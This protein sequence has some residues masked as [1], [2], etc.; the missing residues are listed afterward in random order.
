MAR[1]AH[2]LGASRLVDRVEHLERALRQHRVH[3]AHVADLAE[4]S[5]ELVLI[6][7]CA[8]L[9]HASSMRHPVTRREG[10]AFRADAD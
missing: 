9:G 1:V 7:G 6:L 2:P 8:L 10:L 4:E 5:T 3:H